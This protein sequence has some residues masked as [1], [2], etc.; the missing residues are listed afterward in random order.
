[1]NN[2]EKNLVKEQRQN[3]K[4]Y[5]DAID[6]I[7]SLD[8]IIQKIYEDHVFGK[9]SEERFIKMSSDYEK[10]QKLLMD[11]IYPLKERSNKAKEEALNT[12][13]FLKLVKSILK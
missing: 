8:T 6:R 5:D 2:T 11:K 3:Q 9:I 7:A 4:E 10:E 13:I 1:M 12:D